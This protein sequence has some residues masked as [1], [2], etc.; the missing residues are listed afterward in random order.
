MEKEPK[1]LV[2]CP[3]SDYHAYC[4]EEYVR[5]IKNLTYK[6]YGILLVDNSA[7]EK[8]SEHLKTLKI[9]YKHDFS[10]VKDIKKKIVLSRNVLRK[11]VLDER[12]DY[13]LSLEQDV[14]PPANVIEQLLQH[15]KKIISGVYYNYYPVGKTKALFP[16]AFR[17]L[18]AEE[19]KEMKEKKEVLKQVNEE[20]YNE[21]MKTNF[22]FS[23]VRVK[24]KPEEVEAKKV[25]K[26]K[27]C[28]LG[29]ILIAREVLE[30]IEFRVDEKKNTYDDAL[31]CDDALA[32]GYDLYLDTA[33][34]CKHLIKK[35][36]W[37]W[38]ELDKEM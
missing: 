5:A 18:T 29:C 19:Q 24:L 38:K 6:N 9:A 21:L 11:K 28:G 37:T 13:F 25:I 35:R 22:D 17:W 16:V 33:V 20:L 3:V 23:Q 2:G 1:V 27:Q 8:F 26:V 31:F 14:I 15:K 32:L 36:P 34:K 4:T 7:T 30:Q 10:G 12:Y